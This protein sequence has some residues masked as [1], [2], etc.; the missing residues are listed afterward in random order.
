MPFFLF[1]HAATCGV[2]LEALGTLGA[3]GGLTAK[4]KKP[5]YIISCFVLTRKMDVSDVTYF[6]RM[7]ASV[8]EWEALKQ[9]F[10]QYDTFGT[11]H[12]GIACLKVYSGL[13][14]VMS[15]SEV[16][17]SGF[18]IVRVKMTSYAVLDC[19]SLRFTSM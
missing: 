5:N 9:G 16:V 13:C 15:L 19:R 12:K 17:D 2:V 11:K 18:L 6:P 8:T 10:T 1:E 4:G 7:S 14:G 3:L